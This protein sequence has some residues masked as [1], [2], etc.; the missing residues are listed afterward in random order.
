MNKSTSLNI[1]LIP[2]EAYPTSRVHLTELFEKE[3]TERGHK[4]YWVMQSKHINKKFRVIEKGNNVFHICESIGQGNIFHNFFNRLLLLKKLEISKK[5]MKDHKIDI[6][7][8]TDGIIEGYISKKI[9]EKHKIPWSFYLTSQFFRLI[10]FIWSISPKR[11]IFYHYVTS[12]VEEKILERYISTSNLFQPITK[13]MAKY[14]YPQVPK[15]NIFPL[16]MCSSR[17]FLRKS[18]QNNL[19]NSRILVYI[20][21]ISVSRKLDFIIKVLKIVIKLKNM[22]N[23]KLLLI[24]KPDDKNIV[25]VLK[26]YANENGVAQNIE[27]IEGCPRSEIPTYLSNAAVGISPIPPVQ[28]YIT[29]SPTK[30]IEY[31]SLGIPAV[32]NKEIHD[33]REVIEKS[34]GGFAVDYNTNAFAIAITALLKNPDKARKLGEKGRNW[35]ARNRTYENLAGS[36]EKKYFETIE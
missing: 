3:M 21:V 2:K 10:Q 28:G 8:S 22:G 20:G 33:Q 9:A 24:G 30:C 34:G 7:Q 26:K 18:N 12:P 32:V 15:E 17:D 6:I 29:S 1:L 5:I 16:P 23:T 14:D 35:I 19:T 13:A 11:K 27:I 36:L 31:L 25:S 4:I